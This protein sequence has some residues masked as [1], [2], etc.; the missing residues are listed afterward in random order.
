MEMADKIIVGLRPQHPQP[1]E[2]RPDDPGDAG[3]EGDSEGTGPRVNLGKKN[4]KGRGSRPPWENR[5]SVGVI[6][7]GPRPGFSLIVVQEK[8]RS[9]MQ[10]IIPDEDWMGDTVTE[11]EAN[12][13]NPLIRPCCDANHFRL[14]LEGTTCDPWNRSAADV[15][16]EDFLAHHPE[17][18]KEVDSVYDTVVL[19]T[20]ATI[21]SM[22]KE[23][24][25]LKLGP[26][27]LDEL[28]LR[29]NCIERKRSVSEL[30]RLQ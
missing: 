26:N 14:H 9:H 11:L 24:R 5:L 7:I 30:C 8:I 18:P 16:V 10:N 19:K 17:Y 13:F 2:I 21:T 1:N 12:N 27:K 22:I 23:Y 3:N 20:R 25:K 6:P 4:R 15:F 28:Q 29:K